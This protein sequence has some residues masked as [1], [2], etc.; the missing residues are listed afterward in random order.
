MFK[1]FASAIILFTLTI[2]FSA[3]GPAAPTVTPAPPAVTPL[4]PVF[5]DT[6]VLPT[7]MPTDTPTPTL[8]PK[9]AARA[10]IKTYGG[11][12]NDRA[13]DILLTADGGTLVAGLANNTGSSHRVNPGDARLVRTDSQGN[14]IWTRDY[15]G[16]LPASFSSIIQTGEEEY[17]ILGE[18]ASSAT[19]DEYDLYLVKVNGEGS[20]IWSHT[21]GGQGLDFGK[22][23]R[24]TADGGYILIGSKADAVMTGNLYQNNIYLVKTDAAG[25]EI[26]SRTYGEQILY[27][28]WGVA[29]TPDGGYVLVG[30]EAVTYDDRN[31]LA[32]KTS[33]S[34][35]V[36]WFHT[37]DLGGRDGGFD[38]T[39]TSDGNIVV[40]CNAS[41]GSG[42]TSAVLLKVDL[43]GNE[44]WNEIIGDEGVGNTFWHIMEDADGGYVI[45]GDTH[46]GVRP[47]TQEFVH[48]ALMVKTNADGEILWQRIF[49]E[50]EYEQAFVGSAVLLPEGGYIFVGSVTPYG[51]TSSDMLW[52]KTDGQG[53]I[54]PANAPK[55]GTL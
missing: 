6:P 23:V 14:V 51:E 29:Q 9:P 18:I 39:L 46:L 10:G 8:V 28:G 45:A 24:R 15:G 32:I 41:M 1:S 50:A 21:Y 34:G 35:D 20:E 49:G 7:A 36:E 11:P 3:C 16:E 37:W 26:W 44:I 17:V 12:D 33:E 52:L 31:V 4:S 54:L 43:E 55:E 13:N 48:G 53:N 38:F 25:N 30:W 2:L 19:S 40:A 42:A 22:M 5:A 47:G 27:L